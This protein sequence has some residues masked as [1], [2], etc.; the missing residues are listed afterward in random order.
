M[1]EI[2]EIAV[3]CLPHG[4]RIEVERP[5][6]RV[7]FG[8]DHDDIAFTDGTAR[9]V[10]HD[11]CA[12]RCV[13]TEVDNGSAER[14]GEKLCVQ[15]ECKRAAADK[16]DLFSF[17][18][19]E[20]VNLVF[21]L[22]EEGFIES[23]GRKEN[24]GA[25]RDDRKR[26]HK[27]KR[28]KAKPGFFHI[29]HFVCT[30]L[31]EL[32]IDEC[33]SAAYG[34][35]QTPCRGNGKRD[36]R[37]GVLT[38]SGS[39]FVKLG[40]AAKRI[41]HRKNDDG[42]HRDENAGEGNSHRGD[43]ALHGFDVPALCKIAEKRHEIARAVGA[44]EDPREADKNERPESLPQNEEERIFLDMELF[45]ERQT[46]LSRDHADDL[47]NTVQT[48]PDDEGPACAVPETADEEYEEEVEIVSC[49]GATVAAERY[50]EI[51]AEP[52]GKADVPSCPEF[53]DGSCS[54]GAV[55]V[56][57]EA[58]AHDSRATD[59][60]IRITGEVAI[61]LYGEENGS[62]DDTKTGGF[63]RI[64]I[65]GVDE[66][67]DQIGNDDLFEETDRHFLQADE[68]VIRFEL[69]ICLKLGKQIVGT[70]DRSRNELR[71]EGNEERVPTEVLFRLDLAA[72]N[73]DNVGKRLEGIEG[74]TDG[75]D[76]LKRDEIR[77]SAEEIP[78]GNGGIRKEVEILEEKQNAERRDERHGKPEFLSALTFRFLNDNG[79]DEGNRC[80]EENEEDQRRIP[81]HIEEIACG[82]ERG[83]LAAFRQNEIQKQ[84][85]RIKNQKFKRIEDHAVFLLS[86]II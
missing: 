81:I 52:C 15:T 36:P 42:K 75:E 47:I 64:V 76:E 34:E 84:D 46:R 28:D 20:S 8:G 66:F 85:Q 73:V 65:N 21:K 2:V 53:L 25:D 38:G 72:I 33:G 86:S 10:H 44:E 56:L 51:I 68:G 29:F 58:N 22:A 7:H 6:L 40:I 26:K 14:F 39:V 17:G 19:V 27:Q 5:C 13:Q 43:R 18:R 60:D 31:S 59:G 3:E 24:H 71:E 45:M 54:V 78:D 16:D 69:M 67:R 30:S 11:L 1:T 4:F 35:E 32:K 63:R 57:H 23:G 62:D 77:F 80:R 74:D 70:L 9:V 37:Y 12:E 41:E 61:D 82:K 79:A 49:L 55:K 50:V 83:P 48:A